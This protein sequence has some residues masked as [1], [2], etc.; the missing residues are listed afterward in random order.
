MSPT[1]IKYFMNE[2][3]KEGKK[4][5]PECLPNPPVGC[6]I[7]KDD[8]IISRGHT[9]KPGL[10]HAEAMAIDGLLNEYIDIKIFVTLEPC[11]FIGRTPSC[12][13]KIIEHKV[14]DVYVGIIDPHPKNNGTGLKILKDNGI[15]VHIGVFENKIRKELEPYLYQNN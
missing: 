10:H 11:S 5:L 15:K 9:Q 14:S 2:A 1:N 6:V 8:E 3:I 13:K 12:A 7:V 4:A